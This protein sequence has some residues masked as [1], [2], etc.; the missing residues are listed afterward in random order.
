MRNSTST[1]SPRKVKVLQMDSPRKCSVKDCK[2][3]GYKLVEDKD[4]SGI[5]NYYCEKCIVS[6]CTVNP[7]ELNIK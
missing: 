5:A 6:I 7:K 1:S 3:L 4:K 2:N